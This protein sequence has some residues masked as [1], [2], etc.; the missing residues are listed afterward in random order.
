M[1]HRLYRTKKRS[2]NQH[3]AQGNNRQNL[4]DALEKAVEHLGT[5]RLQQAETVCRNILEHEP[6]NA[7]TL[8]ILGMTAYQ[9]GNYDI[10][11]DLV[12]NAVAIN[13]SVPMYHNGLGVVLRGQGKLDE[14]IECYQKALDLRPDFAGVH[15]N[16]GNVFKDQGRLDEAIE[17]YQKELRL[18]PD[19]ADAHNNLGMML[20]DQGRL[21]EAIECYQKALDLKPDFAGAHYNLGNVLA[22]QG[23]LDEAIECY[24]KALRLKPDFADAHNNLGNVLKDQGRR[25]EAMKCY[26]KA[27]RLKPDFADAHNNLGNVLADGGRPDEAIQCLQKALRLKPD[28]AGAYNNFGSVLGDQGRLDEAIQ[29]YR[30]AL[31]LEPDS[32]SVHSNFLLT[33]HYHDQVDRVQLFSEHLAWAAKHASPFVTAIQSHLNDRAPARRLRVGYVSPDFRG[34]SVAYFIEAVIASH[35]CT[36]IETICYSDVVQPDSVTNRLKGLAS[37]WWDIV[38]MSDEQVADTV[39][40]DQIDILVD[41]SGHTARNRMLLFAR[42]PA[43]I[44]VTYL[45]YPNTTGLSTID[46]RITDSLTDPRGKADHLCVEELFRLPDSFLCYKPPEKTPSVTKIPAQETGSITFGSF[47]HRAKITPEVVKL[48]SRILTLVGNARLI[49]KSKS[50]SAATTQELLRRMFIQN[51]ISPERIEFVSHIPS[52]FEHLKLYNSVDIALDTFPYNGTTTTCEA[53]WMGVPVI[54]LAGETHASRVGV[55]LLSNVGLPD[56]IA[57]YTEEYVE[58][59]VQLAGDLERLQALR[60]NLRSMMVRS[61]LMDARGFTRSLEEAYRQMWRRWCHGAR[62]RSEEKKDA[63]PGVEK[64]PTRPKLP[65]SEQALAINQQGEDFFNAGDL[66]E[67]VATFKKAIEIDPNCV[68][69][70]NNLGVLYW[71]T[72]EVNK[73]IESFKR[74]LE[75]DPGHR[76]TILNLTEV[77]HA[78][79]PMVDAKLVSSFSLA[80]SPGD[81]MGTSDSNNTKPGIRILHHMARSGGTI[82]SRC[83]GCM[84]DV[85]L[86][87]EIHPLGSRLV[88]SQ[89]VRVKTRK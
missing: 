3:N 15:N 7:D 77:L 14:A 68:V 87:S 83:L 86:L 40:N 26:Q 9:K 52:Q 71:H 81:E 22:D 70:H 39:R 29:C 1:G 82:I 19:F 47:N 36:A 61:P 73:A 49:L 88:T 21:D 60:A 41:L 18:R 33:L 44:Q 37:C 24:Q 20:K 10:A 16:L 4:I 42:K 62:E 59:A 89:K 56:L 57:K 58:K 31:Q 27:L 13:A 80:D 50:L 25:D 75:I 45:G 12:N 43:P 11:F 23:R 67:A 76:D 65:V 8:Y 35:D 84:K 46:Y 85:I 79:N 5:G 64:V 51:G 38:G 78:L 6:D 32:P 63:S 48:W 34:H 17:C 69:A 72:G 2:K 74:A 30:K 54:A 53:M 66:A 28:F 55:S